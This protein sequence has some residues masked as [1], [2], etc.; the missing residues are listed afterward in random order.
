MRTPLLATITSGLLLMGGSW[1]LAQEGAPERLPEPAAVAPP[2]PGPGCVVPVPPPLPPVEK[3]IQHKQLI[4][5]PEQS[6]TTINNLL[7][8]KVECGTTTIT[9]VVPEFPETKFSVTEFVLK[10]RTVYQEVVVCTVEP[11]QSTDPVTG[12]TCT[13]FEKVS[14]V[15]KVALTVYDLVPEQR[16]LALRTAVVTT[17]E[18]PV[19]IERMVVDEVTEAAIINRLRVHPVEETIPVPVPSCPPLACPIK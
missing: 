5:V 13:T 4:V 2:M 17:K 12:K 19:K 3:I 11:K 14:K 7:P 6:A 9:Q 8:R 16:Q 18:Q 1:T 15:Q 10:P